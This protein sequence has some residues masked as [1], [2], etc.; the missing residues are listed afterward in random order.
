VLHAHL[1]AATTRAERGLVRAERHVEGLH[2]QV[3][4]HDPAHAL[5]RGWTITTTVDGRPVSR[6]ADLAPG[7]SLVTRFADGTVT[8]TV[9]EVDTRPTDVPP[10][11]STP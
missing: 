9:T 2:A 11:E 5:A 7:T 6:V 8:S 4:A 10:E 3:R 1:E